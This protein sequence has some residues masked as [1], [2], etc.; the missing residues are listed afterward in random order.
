MKKTALTSLAAVLIL[1]GLA[2]Q[3]QKPLPD[4]SQMIQHRVNMLTNKLG[5]SASQQEQATTIFTNAW[6]A[7]K[8]LHGQMRTAHE[9]LQ[10]AVSK[11]DAAGIEQ[12]AN[13]IGS[14]TAQSISA[15]AK[16]EAAFLQTLNSQ[17]QSTYS[18]MRHF[19][20]GRRG[21]EGHRGFG[22]GGPGGP[23]PF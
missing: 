18:Q 5:L 1:A 3:A 21:F 10:A 14:L 2:A 11:N 23:E 16:A 17:Q 9:T 4:P 12:A 7:Q 19:H 6:T 8:S 15:H 22:P 13:N 20:D